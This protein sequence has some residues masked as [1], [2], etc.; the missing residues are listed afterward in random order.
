MGE[1]NQFCFVRT[2]YFGV[3]GGIKWPLLTTLFSSSSGL[4]I[5]LPEEVVLG[6]VNFACDPNLKEIRLMKRFFILGHNSWLCNHS[7]F[8]CEH[9]TLNA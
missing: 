7:A 5:I 1:Q 2:L 8:E 4:F 6:L 3:A 9:Y